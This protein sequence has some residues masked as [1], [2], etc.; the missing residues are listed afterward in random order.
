MT[1][2]TV[3]PVIGYPLIHWKVTLLDLQQHDTD[4]SDIAFENA[5]RIAFERA[6]TAAAPILLEPIMKIE[7]VTP[8]DYFGSINGDLHSRRAVITGTNIRGPSRVIDA[9][10][11]LSETFGYVTDLRSLSQGRA[12]VSMEPLRYAPVPDSVVRN[13]MGVA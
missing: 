13:M 3:G 2:L 10:V 6:T 9:E 11:P 12:W 1:T 8:D 7:V 5:G 4:S